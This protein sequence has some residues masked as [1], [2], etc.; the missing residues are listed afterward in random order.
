MEDLPNSN[1]GE[2]FPETVAVA[3]A[4]SSYEAVASFRHPEEFDAGLMPYSFPVMRAD[5]LDAPEL[6]LLPPAPVPEMGMV[7]NAFVQRSFDVLSF[8]AGFF[9]AVC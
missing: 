3:P 4:D 7:H 2:I 8:V 9:C 1:S 6:E 5:K